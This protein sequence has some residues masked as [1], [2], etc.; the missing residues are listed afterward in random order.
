MAST[1]E[2][3]TDF[4]KLWFGQTVSA[5]GDKIS[6]IALPTIA[7][8]DL[9]G[10]AVQVGILA[11]LGSL[12]Y[13]LLS[14]FAG[15]WVDRLSKRSVL[16]ITDTGRLVALGCIPLAYLLNE[17]SLML[18]YVVAGVVAVLSLFFELAYQT[19]IPTLVGM[20][21]I[22]EGNQKMMVTKAG[23]TTVGSAIGG[24]TMQ[25]LGNALAVLLDSLS[26]IVSLCGLL[27]IKHR[28][29]ARE[30]TR[31]RADNVFAE[32][33]EGFRALGSDTRLRSLML[34][35]TVVNLGT[36]IAAALIIVY[37]YGPAG[38]SQGLVGATFAA[39]A[40]GLTAGGIMARRLSARFSLSGTLTLCICLVGGA[41]LLIALTGV[42]VAMAALTVGQFMVGFAS[43]AFGVNVMS[44]VQT[45]TPRHLL[46]R[47]NGTALFVIFGSATFGGL[48][49]AVLGSALGVRGGLVA[50]GLLSL[51]GAGFVL[52]TP[53]RAVRRLPRPDQPQKREESTVEAGEPVEATRSAG[54]DESAPQPVAASG[55]AHSAEDNN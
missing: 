1:L 14:P 22:A 15:V 2:N 47:I 5:V 31:E 52:L 39:G 9:H 49:S 43:S 50:A 16:L 17:L 26:F 32:M 19:Y 21:G 30:L 12:P 51:S 44:L 48:I 33:R 6:R 42:G 7:V 35:T 40:I 18:L 20:S 3:R 13:L 24:I 11:A 8:L 23:A 4:N 36:A 37:A 28:E 45:I 55:A 10:G 29:P 54:P 27:L 41:I 34:T 38:L 53:L 46:G 25:A